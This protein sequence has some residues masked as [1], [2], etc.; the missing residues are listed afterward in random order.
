MNKSE[1]GFLR[2][3]RD[4]QARG[5][6][7]SSCRSAIG[8]A[9]QKNPAS[10]QGTAIVETALVIGILVLLI[11]GGMDFAIQFHVRHCMTFAAREAARYLAV[12][13]GTVAQAETAALNQLEGIN[14]NF[15]ITCTVGA[16]DVTVNI[17]VPRKDISI[18]FFPGAPGATLTAKT[19][20]RKEI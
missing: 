2:K 5:F 18:G 9:M 12:R 13:N 8:M 16:V 3:N 6:S 10:R 14:A 7:V 11:I 15:T 1:I 4:H 19:T 17:S 20:M